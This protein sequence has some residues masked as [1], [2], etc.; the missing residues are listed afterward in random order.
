MRL[1]IPE[2]GTCIYK[3]VSD[4]TVPEITDSWAAWICYDFSEIYRLRDH[5]RA[6][7]YDY[8][9]EAIIVG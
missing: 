2:N 5:S 8:T 7:G 4:E 1:S 3:R 6:S 9:V